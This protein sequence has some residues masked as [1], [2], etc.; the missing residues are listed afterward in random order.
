MAGG[1]AGKRCGSDGKRGDRSAGGTDLYSGNAGDD[2]RRTDGDEE[3]VR[4]GGDLLEDVF[5]AEVGVGWGCG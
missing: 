2:D 5:A 3:L 4:A 1:F